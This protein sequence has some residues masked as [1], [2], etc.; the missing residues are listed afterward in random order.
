MKVFTVLTL[1]LFATESCSS[2]SSHAFA[3]DM[4]KTDARFLA[5]EDDANKKTFAGIDWGVGPSLTIDTGSNDRVE[6]ASLDP[7]GVVR[8]D[9][10]N[11]E[12]VRLTLETH[13]FFQTEDTHFL[14]LVDP[15]LWGWGPFVAIQPGEDEI[16]DAIGFGVMC[17]F[18]YE[19]DKPASFNVGLGMMVD[20]NVQ[21]LGDG[22][23]ENQPLPPG[24]TDIRFKEKAQWGVM[25]MFSFTF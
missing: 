21:V 19:E 10:E 14:G 25:L 9:D 20:P 7:N 1:V 11:N 3:L 24:E 6:G 22:I 12:V 15:K 18:R 13:Y 16:I 17:G 23:E 4:K 8:V 5:N 2:T